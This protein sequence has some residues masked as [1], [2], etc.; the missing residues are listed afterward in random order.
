MSPPLRAFNEGH[1]RLRVARAQ[2]T[3]RVILPA[4]GL[5]QHPA[6]SLTRGSTGS[7]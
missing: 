1:L 2:G 6:K 7:C 3:H 4:G 5:F